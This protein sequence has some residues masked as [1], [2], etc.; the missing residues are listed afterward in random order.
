MGLGA[1]P[2]IQSVFPSVLV[3]KAQGSFWISFICPAEAEFF[4][5]LGVLKSF[6]I[7]FAAPPTFKAPT[8][9]SDSCTPDNRT[10][11]CPLRRPARV[12]ATRR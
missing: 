12:A 11:C 2:Y 4:T 3:D 7:F 9:A 5:Q 6:W 1:I 8:V 10:I